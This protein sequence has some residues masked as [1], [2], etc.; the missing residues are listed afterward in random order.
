VEGSQV[1]IH[2][3][4]M[5]AKVIATA[6]SR[7]MAIARLVAALRQYAILGV[8]TNIPF[9]IKV[10][11]DPRFRAGDVDTGFLDRERDIFG[12]SSNGELPP[13]LHDALRQI[14]DAAGQEPKAQSAK[15]EAHDPWDRLKGWRA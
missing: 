1:S 3:D 6:E 11:E 5:L 8:R 10:L 13:F 2:Y 4:P 14:D 9:L 7:D 12:H 15:P